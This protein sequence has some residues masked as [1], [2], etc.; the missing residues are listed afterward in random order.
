[1]VSDPTDTKEYPTPES[2][3]YPQ[4][5]QDSNH[6]TLV[7]LTSSILY[8]QKVLQHFGGLESVAN[9]RVSLL[10]WLLFSSL[11]IKRRKK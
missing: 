2:C 8:H 6:L 3:G 10:F 7:R 4:E 1:M 9:V 5:T 11:Y